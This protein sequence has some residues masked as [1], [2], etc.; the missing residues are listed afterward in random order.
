V[1]N[2]LV[3]RAAPSL[4][5]LRYQSSAK[6]GSL[7]ELYP[8][9]IDSISFYFANLARLNLFDWIKNHFPSPF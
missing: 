7:A 4:R 3:E 8:L 9:P 5:L 6:A 1:G 2:C